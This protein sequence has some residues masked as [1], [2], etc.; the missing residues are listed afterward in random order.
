MRLAYLSYCVR[1]SILVLKTRRLS[2]SR[3]VYVNFDYDARILISHAI[4]EL[5]FRKFCGL[6]CD[7]ICESFYTLFICVYFLLVFAHYV[8]THVVFAYF[9]IFAFCFFDYFLHITLHI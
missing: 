4:F 6:G 5:I 3:G 2:I 1:K 8:F 7:F 9:L